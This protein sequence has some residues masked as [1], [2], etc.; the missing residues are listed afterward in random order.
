VWESREAWQ[1]WFDGHVT[2][3]LPPGVE[4]TTPEMFEISLDVTPA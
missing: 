1:A 2:P 3:K 4:A